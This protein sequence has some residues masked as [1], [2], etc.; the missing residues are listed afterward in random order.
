MICSGTVTPG[1]ST[2]LGNGKIGIISGNSATATLS[3]GT[4]LQ[5]VKARVFAVLRDSTR[6]HKLHLP[7]RHCYST[8]APAG[9]GAGDFFFVQ[10][11]RLFFVARTGR[12]K[13][14]RQRSRRAQ[15]AQGV[16]PVK[17]NMQESV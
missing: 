8:K 15:G 10:G 14:A 17:A 6:F 11:L 13:T 12:D 16:K 9:T 7:G 5:S 2:K 3:L 1:K 4:P